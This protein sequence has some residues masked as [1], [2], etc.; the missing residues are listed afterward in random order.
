MIAFVL[1]AAIALFVIAYRIYG[2]WISR[3]FEL[4]DRHAV[5]SETLYDGTDYVPAKTAVLFGHHFSSIAGAGPVIGPILAGLFFGWVPALLWIVVGSIFV[6][7]VHDFG[8]MVASV[9]HKAKSIAELARQYMSPLSYKLF[10]AFI[11]LTLVYVIVVFLDLTAVSFIDIP[12]EPGTAES[13]QGT[14]VAVASGIF[15]VLAIVLGVV[16]QHSKTPLWQ[17]TVVLVPILVAGAVWSSGITSDG[18]YLPR[19]LGDARETWSVLL[20]VYCFIASVTPVWA[21]LHPRDYLSS[22]LL[23]LAVLGGGTGLL[24]GSFTGTIQPNYPAFVNPADPIFQQVPHLGP[25]FPILFITIACGACS[26]FHS[27][28]SSG[29]TSKQ[30]SCETDARRIGYG[31]MLTEGVVAVISLSCVMMLGFSA[32]SLGQNPVTV[33][34][35]GMG[36]FLNAFG[37]PLQV[38]S[39]L[40]LLTLSTFLLT[41]LDTCTRLGRYVLQEFFQ[42]DNTVAVNRVKA[43]VLTLVIP[44]IMAYTTY[45]TPSGQVL[46]VWRAIWPVFGSTNQLLAGLALLAVTFWMKRTGR[47]WAF[48]A[49]PTAFMITMTMTALVLQVSGAQTVMPVRIIAGS[50]LV[51]GVVLVTE[52]IRIFGRPQLPRETILMRESVAVT[53]GD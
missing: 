8:S 45:T 27:M 30:V 34:A 49:V 18:N 12:A 3:Q 22:F 39:M 7:G 47:K 21:L 23:Y 37:I 48:V 24:I 10:L 16:N 17:S 1:L 11:W 35:K 14:G 15:L 19:L 6:G 51:L 2:S 41:T 38:G 33:Y 29:T 40:G 9:R 28:V 13:V 32:Q 26:G 44:V 52:A 20:L 50:L 36:Q 25:L 43:T 46:P 5:P 53:P 4:D 42:W 31:G